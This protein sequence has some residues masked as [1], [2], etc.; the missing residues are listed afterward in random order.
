MTSKLALL[1]G[2]LCIAL[3]SDVYAQGHS[4][5]VWEKAGNPV[6]DENDATHRQVQ[7]LLVQMVPTPGD[8]WESAQGK[9]QLRTA[10]DKLKEANA[11]TAPDVR[12]RFDLGEVFYE[13]KEDYASCA[14]SLRGALNEA[15]DHPMATHAYFM[16]AICYA[17]LKDPAHEIGCY[18][19]VLRR[20]SNPNTRALVFSNRAEAQMLLHNLIPAIADYR[21]ALA[22]DP[23][24]ALTH[25]GLALALDR[26]GDS[27]GA[28]VEAKAAVTYDPLDQQLGRPEVFFMPPYDRYFYE[29]IGAMARAQLADDPA[30]AVLW[31]EA[32]VAKW[33]EYIASAPSSDP[34]VTLAQAHQTSSTR[35]L[36]VAKKKLARA[37]KG[38]KAAQR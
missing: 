22:L 7:A 29:A 1:L 30:A 3:G 21:A 11:E 8:Y 13:L 10:L 2:A 35:Q 14:R 6:L 38:K 24:S 32:A 20:E 12:L 33:L 5:G 18:D 9:E 37:P 23:D 15:P 36:E 16:L 17:K 27:P 25:W 4:P 28:M 19:E 34:W 31:W 26:S